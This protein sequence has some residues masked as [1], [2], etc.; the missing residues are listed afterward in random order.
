MIRCHLVVAISG[1]NEVDPWQTPP[2]IVLVNSCWLERNT[3]EAVQCSIL[4]FSSLCAPV[5]M[6]GL[7]TT[8][9]LGV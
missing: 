7:V 3:R 1:K 2:M 9:S 6:A 4:L 5:L 8:Y